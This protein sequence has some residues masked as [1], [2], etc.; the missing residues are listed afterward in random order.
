M[1]TAHNVQRHLNIP[2]E[3][4][5]S[6]PQY[7]FSFL[8]RERSGFAEDVPLTERIEVGK[9]VDAIRT[10]PGAARMISPL[11]PEA[12]R[13][14]FALERQFGDILPALATQVS[15]TGLLRYDGWEMPVR[16]RPDYEL[17]GRAIVDL[18]VTATKLQRP[19]SPLTAAP[20]INHMKYWSQLFGYARLAGAT[21]RY[22]L[23]YC[24]PLK[25]AILLPNPMTDSDPFWEAAIQRFG[26]PIKQ[27]IKP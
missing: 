19:L 12:K 13:I 10:D 24:R 7:S 11:Y 6:W 26:W 5:F 18:K 27:I 3:T 15:Y 25:E 23:I 20:L 21:K 14:A 22:L 16:G 8:K 9:L 1:I 4:Y 2:A 17:P